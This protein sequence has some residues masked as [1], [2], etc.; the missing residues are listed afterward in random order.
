MLREIGFDRIQRFSNGEADV[1]RHQNRIAYTILKR[2]YQ[3]N[4][5]KSDAKKQDVDRDEPHLAHAVNECFELELL[6]RR[7]HPR[8]VFDPF[9]F[10]SKCERGLIAALAEAFTQ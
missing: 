6:V 9:P 8:A 7:Q 5:R 10:L 1:H 3:T 2:L 4:H